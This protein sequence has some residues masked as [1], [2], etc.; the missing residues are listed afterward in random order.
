MEKPE[1]DAAVKECTTLLGVLAVLPTDGSNPAKDAWNTIHNL[2]TYRRMIHVLKKMEAALHANKGRQA[3]FDKKRKSFRITWAFLDHGKSV[4]AFFVDYRLLT[5]TVYTAR[6]KLNGVLERS[7][8]PAFTEDDREKLGIA[9]NALISDYLDSIL[10]DLSNRFQDLRDELRWDLDSFDVDPSMARNS[11]HVHWILSDLLE[12]GLSL[13][14]LVV[15]GG[16][17]SLH[18]WIAAQEHEFQMVLESQF[19]HPGRVLQ[20]LLKG[21]AR[22]DLLKY[23][24]SKG[25]DAATQLAVIMA[26][27][28]LK[29]E[30]FNANLAGPTA[31]TWRDIMEPLLGRSTQPPHTPIKPK[32][33][34]LP[35]RTAPSPVHVPP[36]PRPPSPGRPTP[37]KTADSDDDDDEEDKTTDDDEDAAHDTPRKPPRPPQLALTPN[38][39]EAVHVFLAYYPILAAAN[40]INRRWEAIGE[41][42]RAIFLNL[43]TPMVIEEIHH[44][45]GGD[46]DLRGA[47]DELYDR[48][49]GKKER[50]AIASGMSEVIAW[51]QFRFRKNVVCFVHDN[52]TKDD[53]STMQRASSG[54]DWKSSKVIACPDASNWLAGVQPVVFEDIDQ[55]LMAIYANWPPKV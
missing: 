47:Y 3:E 28:K 23:S 11:F 14:R 32:P 48:I 49:V 20:Y 52:T 40:K 12:V 1:Q 34:V 24:I 18:E 22:A 19:S 54:I 35:P 38:E 10:P 21:R 51:R 31:L 29:E 7:F 5:S 6:T 42:T 36:S 50:G 41:T 9:Y 26:S 44:V 17:A 15:D 39:K 2:E 4:Q 25:K 8:T 27:P 16:R 43:I 13:D 53:R 37:T 45:L 30:F 46:F 33:D 55:E